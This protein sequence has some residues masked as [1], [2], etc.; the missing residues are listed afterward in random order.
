MV[1]VEYMGVENAYLVESD[2]SSIAWVIHPDV[3]VLETGNISKDP[4]A[5]LGFQPVG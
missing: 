3:E 4:L 5:E 1:L 2:D